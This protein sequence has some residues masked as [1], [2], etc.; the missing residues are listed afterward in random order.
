M[1]EQVDE[2]QSENDKKLKKRKLTRARSMRK[3]SAG[4]LKR[5]GGAGIFVTAKSGSK[6]IGKGSFQP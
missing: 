6:L 3:Q 5:P 2:K 4:P 1:A